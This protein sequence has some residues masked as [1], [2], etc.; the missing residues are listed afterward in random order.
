MVTHTHRMLNPQDFPVRKG[1]NLNSAYTYRPIHTSACFCEWLPVCGL[2][3]YISFTCLEMIVFVLLHQTCVVCRDE[4]CNTCD[5]EYCTSSTLAVLWSEQNESLHIVV[6]CFV[7]DHNP[8]SA[9]LYWLMLVSFMP[10]SC[11]VHSVAA[12]GAEGEAGEAAGC[13]GRPAQSQRGET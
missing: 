8:V 11:I 9:F 3:F 10:F 12:S 2:F 7:A 5:V 13:P 6:L 4:F 1:K